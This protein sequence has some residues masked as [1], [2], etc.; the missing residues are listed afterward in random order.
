MAAVM[1]LSC[2]TA[3]AIA[4]SPD[5]DAAVELN[6][7]D[8]WGYNVKLDADKT[9]EIV[10]EYTEDK[11]IPRI[12]MIHEL[13]DDGNGNAITMDELMD[14]IKNTGIPGFTIESLEA[15]AD[16]SMIELMEVVSKD[17]NGYVVEFDNAF[18]AS[19]SVSL[20]IKGPFPSYEDGFIDYDYDDEDDGDD[21][22]G[23]NDSAIKTVV[24]DNVRI[25]FMANISGTMYLNTGMDLVDLVSTTNITMKMDG[26]SNV[27][28]V[29]E[30]DDGDDYKIVYHPAENLISESYFL[31]ATQDS[32]LMFDTPVRL[33]PEYNQTDWYR[34]SEAYI[35]TSSYISS[36]LPIG[37]DNSYVDVD[38]DDIEYSGTTIPAIA[39]VIPEHY[40]L[41]LEGISIFY[42]ATTDPVLSADERDSIRGELNGIIGDIDDTAKDED[43]TVK[44]LD[45]DDKVIEKLT[46]TVKYGS[47]IDMPD[48]PSDAARD[49]DDDDDDE[50]FI[51]WEC[52]DIIWT[53]DMPIRSNMT[54]E[55]EFA[56]RVT[57]KP[58]SPGASGSIVWEVDDLDDMIDDILDND[59]VEYGN[60][61]YIDVKDS[62]GKVLYSWTSPTRTPTSTGPS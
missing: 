50:V 17:S 12:Q 42:P 13:L 9:I 11:S 23:G 14:K 22:D 8:S 48:F 54:F 52:G 4:S 34:E 40:M 20:V 57:D 45:G 55:P 32:E 62:N 35:H 38:T 7:G 2:L 59:L 43:L 29:P 31:K 28:I 53:S 25:A 27:E 61:L 41:N 10:H 44:F 1:L 51:G 58:T 37:I 26:K 18:L 39:D 36:N 49:D 46:K 6:Q 19:A 47:T 56:D 30:D 24:L 60:T 21:D 15:D 3:V 5:A 33:F 16:L